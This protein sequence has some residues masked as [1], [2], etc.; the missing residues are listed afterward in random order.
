MNI[1]VPLKAGKFINQRENF[2]GCHLKKRTET[3]IKWILG[4][5]F[6]GGSEDGSLPTPEAGVF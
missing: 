6:C 4:E 1:Q 5:C 3:D 2:C